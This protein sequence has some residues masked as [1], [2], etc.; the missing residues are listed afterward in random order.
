MS[1]FKSKE[2]KFWE[3][4]LKNDTLLFNFEE[5]Q[6][7]TFSELN[8]ALRKVHKDL[9]FVFGPIISNRREFIVSADGFASLIPFVAKL[10]HSA[11]KMNNWTVLAFRP[12]QDGPC[13][14]ELNGIKVTDK[15][16]KFDFLDEINN[17]I[18]L[19]IHAKGDENNRANYEMAVFIFL[20]HY[21]GEYDVM[22]KV[23]QIK[24]D[25]DTNS[26]NPIEK[27]AEYWKIR[28]RNNR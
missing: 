25:F 10:V 18:G 15:D 7:A 27:L 17:R 26:G 24:I 2:E 11:P 14:I 19:N 23:G 4:F 28:A 5:N 12:A 1:L 3:W 8:N 21:I 22:T 20:D 9:T 13:N 16:L 6:E